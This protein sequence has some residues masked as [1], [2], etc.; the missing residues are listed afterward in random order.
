ML[1]D[2]RRSLGAVVDEGTYGLRFDGLPAT[3]GLLGATRPHWPSVR[4]DTEVGLPSPTATSWIDDGGA[5]TVLPG[6]RSIRMWRAEGRALV[7]APRRPPDDQL[8]HPGLSP[9]AACFGAWAGYEALHGAAFV[10]DGRAWGLIAEKEGGKSPTVGWLHG[11]G[12][13]VV[14]DD[15]VMVSGPRVFSGPRCIDLREEAAAAL[16]GRPLGGERQGKW[17]VDLPQAEPDYRLGGWVVLRWADDVLLRR[18]PLAERLAALGGHRVWGR[19]RPDRSRWL[20]MAARP[21]WE[22][23]RPRTWSSLKPSMALLVDA[24]QGAPV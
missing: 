17:R 14:A 7:T 21:A 12:Y 23:S 10:V 2:R 6:T 15:M 13:T 8:V 24:L 4:V 19:L 22:L 5:A 11:Q 18:L 3:N 1:H 20:D 9:I 16:G